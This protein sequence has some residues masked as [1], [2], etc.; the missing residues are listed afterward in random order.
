[1]VRAM[2]KARPPAKNRVYVTSKYYHPSSLAID[3]QEKK[4][5][6]AKKKA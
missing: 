6:N 3:G 1:M 4:L 5:R 2:S